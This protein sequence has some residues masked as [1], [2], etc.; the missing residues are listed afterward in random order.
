MELKRFLLDI[1]ALALGGSIVAVFAYYMVRNDLVD[2][3]RTLKG[4]SNN[5]ISKSEITNLSIQAHERMVIFID[6]INPENLLLRLHSA[7]IDVRTLQM[8]AAQEINAEFQH[9]ITQQLYLSPTTWNVIAKI[10]E[11]TIAMINAAVDGLP[12]EATGVDLSK[13]VLLY[14]SNQTESP[15]N[16]AIDLVKQDLKNTFK[17]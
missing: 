7:G 10:K 3:L 2:F 6:R 1:A 5:D 11:D 15:Y 16:L 8:L 17:L 4:G 12:K 9:N 13:R 14:M